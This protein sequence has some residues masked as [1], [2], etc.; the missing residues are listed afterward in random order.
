M[1]HDPIIE[2]LHETRDRLAKE[3]NYDV[4]AIV[5][6]ARAQQEKENHPIVSFSAKRI[7][8]E[9]EEWLPE[10]QAA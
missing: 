7:E 6:Q 10:K 3:L 5:A 1:M 9:P 2:A 4:Y 8:P